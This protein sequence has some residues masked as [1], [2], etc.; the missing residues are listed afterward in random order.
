M[1][2]RGGLIGMLLLLSAIIM[3]LK[4]VVQG[5]IYQ[6]QIINNLFVCFVFVNLSALFNVFIE[7]PLYASIYWILFGILNTVVRDKLAS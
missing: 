2:V 6:N 1:L 3:Q 5:R 4:S 7:T